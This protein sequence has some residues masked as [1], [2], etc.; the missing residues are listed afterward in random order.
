VDEA[1]DFCQKSGVRLV[2]AQLSVDWVHDAAR[3]AFVN[4]PEETA[5]VMGN[6]RRFGT[7]SVM[8][9]GKVRTV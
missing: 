8:E 5:V 3:W 4:L 7:L 1:W 9:W 6:K 2:Y